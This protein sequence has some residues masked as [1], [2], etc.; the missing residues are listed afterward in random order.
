[1]GKKRGAQQGNLNA[2]KH[3]AYS[4]I[5]DPR[6]KEARLVRWIE[7]TLVQALGDPSPQELLLAKR[8]AVKAFRCAAIESEILSKSGAIPATLEQNYLRWSRELRE[9]L[10]TLGLERRAKPVQDLSTYLS[11]QYG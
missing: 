7:D 5:V 3:G 11:E 2:L 1:M 4:P 8:A 10:K 6:T 9:D